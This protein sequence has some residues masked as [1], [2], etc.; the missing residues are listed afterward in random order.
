MLASSNPSMLFCTEEM[1]LSWISEKGCP[2]AGFV[3]PPTSL[4]FTGEMPEL[5]HNV[6]FTFYIPASVDFRAVDAVM[7]WLNPARTQ[8]VVVGV[9]IALSKNHSDS[10]TKFFQDWGWW[11][12][13][14]DCPNVGFRF[15]WVL[16]NTEGTLA[17]ED[18]KAGDR[19]LHSVAKVRPPPSIGNH[20]WNEFWSIPAGIAGRYHSG[21][22]PA[23]ARGRCR[24]PGGAPGV[25]R[26]PQCRLPGTVG[27]T[28]YR[29]M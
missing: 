19:P 21:L 24:P 4:A 5:T 2:C 26:V 18:V 29:A 28:E 8:A 16:E 27:T 14:L 17:R 12:K 6:G 1:I 11:K 9:Q 10:E 20:C 22:C 25:R 13:V 3:D 7:V 15:R 23:P